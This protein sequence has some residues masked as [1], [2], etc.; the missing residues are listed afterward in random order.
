MRDFT[1]PRFRFGLMLLPMATQSIN[2]VTMNYQEKG[3]GLPVVLIHGFPLDS[4]IWAGQL[5][6]L[7]DRYRVIAPDLR[8][9]GGTSPAAAF[10]MD[11]LAEDLHSLLSSIGALPAVVG[12]LSMGGY[13]A[14]AYAKKYPT[15]LK[16]LMLFDTR[17]EGDN[18][19]AKEKR[20][21]M[22]EKLKKGGSKA[23]AD[24]MHPKMLHE[25]TCSNRPE[26]AH[27][28]RTIMESQPPGTIAH[29]IAALRDR[30]DRTADLPSIA[31]PTLVM[32]GESDA[33]TP[34]ARS[35]KMAGAI[36]R[37]KLVVIPEAGHM[38]PME[39]PMEANS[40]IRHFLEGLR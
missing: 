10:S 2:G 28:L 38:A 12:G 24:D 1:Y 29:A 5:E 19:E 8:G 40:G 39:Q 14:L 20:N 35:E 33:I 34:P 7:S 21:Q 22:L 27:K 9:F 4:R 13:V 23:I 26:I 30:P 11:S 32:V 36:A 15:D 16:A 18:A 37:S 31:V 6:G 3:S 17:A 25:A